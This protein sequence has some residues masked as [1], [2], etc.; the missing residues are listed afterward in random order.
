M[1]VIVTITKAYGVAELP[2]TYKNTINVDAFVN[3]DGDDITTHTLNGVGDVVNDT[4]G[5]A[6]DVVIYGEHALRTTD[7]CK[8]TIANANNRAA[9][10]RLFQTLTIFD[11]LKLE[12]E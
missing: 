7:T 5:G 6:T 8:L 3:V 12:A 2:Q 9:F 11:T 4:A 10:V 1:R